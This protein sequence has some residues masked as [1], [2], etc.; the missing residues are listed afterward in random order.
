MSPLNW[1]GIW[2]KSKQHLVPH[3]KLIWN[4]ILDDVHSP[5]LTSI[6]VL[7]YININ[8]ITETKIGKWK[9]KELVSDK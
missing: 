2:W 6:M 3:R 8:Y 4:E 5:L 1:Y 9:V 7:F